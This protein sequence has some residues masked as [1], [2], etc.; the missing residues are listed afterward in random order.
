MLVSV[1]AEDGDGLKRSSGLFDLAFGGGDALRGGLS[2]GGE[3]AGEYCDVS[4]GS[5][6]M[7]S[8][9]GSRELLYQ[10][11]FPALEEEGGKEAFLFCLDRGAPP[12]SAL[13]ASKRSTRPC[14][15]LK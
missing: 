12:M 1:L 4:N 9:V 13:C 7:L 15:A 10:A 14:P 11:P 8:N 6:D 3:T 2:E 5:T